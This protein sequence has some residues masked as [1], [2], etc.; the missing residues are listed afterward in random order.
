MDD[1]RIKELTEEVLHALYRPGPGEAGSAGGPASALEAR[2]A[3]LE[4]RLRRLQDGP[5]EAQGACAPSI[6]A[7]TI[8]GPNAS[9]TTV[10]N[11][12]VATHPALQLLNVTGSS[13]GRC[14]L[15]ADKPC[16]GSGACKTYGH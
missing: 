5:G 11:A 2:V 12:Q 8:A 16:V 14:V 13:D 15:D 4:A 3:A 10:I 9:A 6:S 7:V 1:T